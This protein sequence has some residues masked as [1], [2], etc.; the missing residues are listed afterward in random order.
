MQHALPAHLTAPHRSLDRVLESRNKRR[1]GHASTVC[2]RSSISS[3]AFF[4]AEEASA[5]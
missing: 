3:F 5:E 2:R 4:T 1:G